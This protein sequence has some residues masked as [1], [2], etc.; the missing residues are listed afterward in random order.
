MSEN[1]ETQWLVLWKRPNDDS[2]LYYIPNKCF[3]NEK[4]LV[5]YLDQHIFKEGDEY[6]V[7]GRF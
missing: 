3:S 4:Q 6:K 7:Q 5:K 1:N 2:W